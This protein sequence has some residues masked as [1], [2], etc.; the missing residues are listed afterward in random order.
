MFKDLLVF[1]GCM[2]TPPQQQNQQ[3]QNEENNTQA[4]YN[5][6]GKLHRSNTGTTSLARQD[7]LPLSNA[8]PPS[9]TP[10]R[11]YKKY[12]QQRAV[13]RMGEIVKLREDDK[14]QH[15]DVI[16][17]MENDFINS[18][19]MFLYLH[20]VMEGKKDQEIDENRLYHVDRIETGENL[21][22]SLIKID[23]DKSKKYKLYFLQ[24]LTITDENDKSTINRRR[25]SQN[26]E[27]NE[28]KCKSNKNTTPGFGKDF[29]RGSVS[30]NVNLM[31]GSQYEI[32]AQSPQF[33]IQ[34]TNQ[35]SRK[36]LLSKKNSEES[37]QSSQQFMSPEFRNN[38]SE[39]PVSGQGNINIQNNFMIN[40]SSGQQ[41][42][43]PNSNCLSPYKNLENSAY[44][45]DKLLNESGDSILMSPVQTYQPTGSEVQIP[46][47]QA[48]S[49]NIL[50]NFNPATR[51]YFKCSIYSPSN[52][53][54]TVDEVTSTFSADQTV[55]QSSSKANTSTKPNFFSSSVRTSQQMTQSLI[56]PLLVNNSNLNSAYQPQ[57]TQSSNSQSRMSNQRHSHSGC[58]FI[59]R[60]PQT[61]R[62]SDTSPCESYSEQ[63]S[64][65]DIQKEDGYT[66]NHYYK[67][68]DATLKNSGKNVTN[69]IPKQADQQ[70]LSKSILYYSNTGGGSGGTQDLSPFVIKVEKKPKAK[71][72]HQQSVN[73][74]GS[75]IDKSLGRYSAPL[76][77]E[78]K[79]STSGQMET[80]S[81]TYNKRPSVMKSTS[82][83]G[84]SHNRSKQQKQSQFINI[85][86]RNSDQLNPN[87]TTSSI[88]SYNSKSIKS[89][90]KNNQTQNKKD[91]QIIK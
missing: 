87:S 82:S 89:S 42:Q 12:E 26:E 21:G 63:S 7:N 16:I 30:N 38:N 23:F 36:S 19:T 20:Q 90:S 24:I 28:K 17:E 73:H 80:V 40:L 66:V 3:H 86:H 74:H 46:A 2:Y 60:S 8:H 55:G 35:A 91:I 37:I 4:S 22:R 41:S 10:Q 53:L 75:S 47:N 71:N 56:Q 6:D 31:V 67:G 76:Y 50:M 70:Q 43:N 15:L 61:Y 34:P 5:G 33:S 72:Q 25:D 51:T 79:A 1:C 11:K 83:S 13:I 48:Q 69:N 14:F 62:M 27:S 65:S 88:K 45:N 59:H 68:A 39:N 32:L 52:R 77:Q 9:L 18:D 84:T 44:K 29:K 78:T 64:T 49:Q 85:Q 57:K 54:Y 58:S 81:S